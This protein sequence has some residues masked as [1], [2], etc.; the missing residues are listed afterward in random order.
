MAV[1]LQVLEYEKAF[2]TVLSGAYACIHIPLASESIH[3]TKE[4][5]IT[6]KIQFQCVGS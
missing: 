1:F 2:I 5:K 6:S 3:D 4:L